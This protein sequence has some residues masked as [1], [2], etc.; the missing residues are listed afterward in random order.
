MVSGIQA[1]NL[2]G[3]SRLAL[4]L[5]STQWIRVQGWRSIWNFLAKFS[6]TNQEGRPQQKTPQFI[7]LW[8]FFKNPVVLHA[9]NVSLCFPSLPNPTPWEPGITV[10]NGCEGWGREKHAAKPWKWFENSW[11]LR[12]QCI[13]NYKHEC[14]ARGGEGLSLLQNALKHEGENAHSL[15][16]GMNGEQLSGQVSELRNFAAVAAVKLI[17]H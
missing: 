9:E 3:L 15:E 6:G 11:L 12:P 7:F 1:T 13:R 14:V 4:G 2:S 17:G 8:G 16:L 5:I 10:S